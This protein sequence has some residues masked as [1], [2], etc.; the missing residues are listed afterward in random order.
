MTDKDLEAIMEK[1]DGEGVESL[2]EEEAAVVCAEF[3]EFLEEFAAVME[4]YHDFVEKTLEEIV[5]QLS[6]FNEEFIEEY[7]ETFVTEDDKQ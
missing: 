4:S 5:E 3:S 7:N 6:E 1:A 2:T